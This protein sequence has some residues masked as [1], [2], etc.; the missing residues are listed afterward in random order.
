MADDKKTVDENV[1]QTDQ[2]GD[3][4]KGKWD[5]GLYCFPLTKKITAYNEELSE[6]K[7]REPTGADIINYGIFVSFDSDNKIEFDTKIGGDQIANLAGI[8]KSSVCQMAPKDIIAIF[9]ILAPFFLP[10]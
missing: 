8:P 2:T 4:N 9:W 3:N 1:T 5:N 10:V 7:L 6:L